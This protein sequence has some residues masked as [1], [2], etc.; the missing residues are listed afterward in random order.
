VT[1]DIPREAV[2]KSFFIGTPEKVAADLQAYVDAGV[3]WAMMADVM[4]F[5]LDIDEAA[6]AGRRAVEV[7]A[8]LKG[9]DSSSSAVAPGA[10]SA[11]R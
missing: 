1:A 6:E 8:I 5:V 3:T 10:T 4:P 11:A 7:C 9:R 2:E